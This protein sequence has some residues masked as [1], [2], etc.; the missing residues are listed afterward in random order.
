M[1]KLTTMA[2]L[3]AC[4]A[5]FP[6]SASAQEFKV[7]YVSLDRLVAESA[8]AK[9]AR[10]ELES[11]FK[12]REKNLDAKSAAIRN[13]QQAYEK[14]FSSLSSAQKELREKELTQNIEAFEIERTKFESELSTAQNQL[15]QSMLAKA[16]AVIKNLAEKEGFDLIVQEAVYIKPKNDLTQRVLER[17]R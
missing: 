17:L 6:L 15:L 10:S 3:L 13:K 14:D 9:A 11:K 12:A 8:P 2:A 16:D 4:A 7:G 5:V 1:K